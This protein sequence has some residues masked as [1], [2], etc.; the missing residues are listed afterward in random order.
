VRM[1]DWVGD[2]DVVVDLEAD[3]E[4]NSEESWSI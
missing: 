2:E 1:V 4:G 3:F